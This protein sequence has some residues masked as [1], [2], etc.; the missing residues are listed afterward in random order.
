VS[1]IRPVLCMSV[2]RWHGFDCS[3]LWLC[4][5]VFVIWSGAGEGG[6]QVVFV[7]LLRLVLVFLTNKKALGVPFGRPLGGAQG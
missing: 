6:M 5:V 4:L 7:D 2:R 3:R 1:C